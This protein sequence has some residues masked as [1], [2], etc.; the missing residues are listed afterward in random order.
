VKVKS[1]EQW[2]P[3]KVDITKLK[4]RFF[5]YLKATGLDPQPQNELSLS[6]VDTGPR[7]TT[8]LADRWARRLDRRKALKTVR[9][10]EDNAIEHAITQAMLDSGASKTFVNSGQGLQLTGPSEKVVV[11]AGGTKLHVTNTGLLST[12]ALSKGAREAIVVPGM[13]QTAL[14][15]IATLANNGYTTVFLPGQQGVDIFRANNVIISPTAPPALQGWQ[16][17]R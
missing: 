16:D 11:T 2:Q 1:T 7:P 10:L 9:Q 12:R 14:I 17:D 4:Q 13:S 3:G 6:V 15:S 5:P 8:K